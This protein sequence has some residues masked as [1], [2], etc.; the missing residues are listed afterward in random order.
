MRWTSEFKVQRRRSSPVSTTKTEQREDGDA[1]RRARQREERAKAEPSCARATFCSRRHYACTHCGLSFEPPSPQLFSFNSPQGMCPECDGLGGS[2][3]SIPSCW[4]PFPKASFKEGCFELIGPWHDLGR[5]RRHI[6]QGVADTM[7]RKLRA[8]SRH[9]ARYAVGEARR[10]AAQDLAVR[11][12]Q[13]AHHVHLARRGSKPMMYGGRF[14]GIVPDL[15]TRYK[16]TKSKTHLKQLEKYM[17]MVRCPACQGS[18]CCRRRGRCGSRVGVRVQQGQA[19]QGTAGQSRTRQSDAAGGLRFA[20]SADAAAVLSGAGS[21]ADAAIIAAEVLKEIRTRL[22]FLIDVGLE[23]L[24]LDRTA[25]TLSGGESQRIRLASQIGSGL[26]GVLYILDEPSIG[27]HPR[28]NDRLLK[29]LRRLRDMGNTV[30]VV[31]HDEETMWAADQIIDFGPGPGV[32]GGELVVQG[33]PGEVIKDKHSL[34]GK[35]LS[36]EKQIEIPTERREGNGNFLKILG[37]THNNLKDIDVEIPLGTFVCITGVSGSG[38]SSL[39]S[40]IIVEALHR[41]LNKGEGNPGRA[42]SDRRAGASRQADRHRSNADRP[43]A[44]QQSRHLHQGVRRNSRSVLPASRGQA[45]RLPGS[46]APGRRPCCGGDSPQ[47]RTLRRR[48][49]GRRV[50]HRRRGGSSDCAG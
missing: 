44:A 2:I 34:T 41:D 31:E 15:T 14:E 12:R 45:P 43:H 8:G 4:S 42:S 3:R 7:E 19:V 37:A 10:R 25:P 30:V 39:V 29:T 38:K 27:L 47:A 28:D 24:T 1:E 32:R 22:G 6:Y 21:Q 23:Y 9:A 49:L 11:H 26:V 13:R 33:P 16:A 35:Y 40:D 17:R 50:P 5:W 46:H 48:D 18:G 36:G 20:R